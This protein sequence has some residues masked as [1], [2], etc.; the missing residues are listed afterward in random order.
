MG[1]SRALLNLGF[2]FLFGAFD[3]FGQVG[4]FGEEG[5]EFFFLKAV[6]GGEV[7]QGIVV[8]R[9]GGVV[10]LFG[11]FFL[12]LFALGDVRFDGGEL[13]LQ[14]FEDARFPAADFGFDAPLRF[15]SAVEAAGPVAVAAEVLDEDGAA[16][17]DV[18]AR[19][20]SISICSR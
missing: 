10:Q 9:D 7:H 16:A 18:S 1:G 20:S 15:R 6:F 4:P 14:R 11:D 17:A 5:S 3:F 19:R 13:V 2:D 8:G 12:A